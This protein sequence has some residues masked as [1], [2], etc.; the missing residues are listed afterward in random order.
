MPA[1]LPLANRFGVLDPVAVNDDDEP[2]FNWYNAYATHPRPPLYLNDRKFDREMSLMWRAKGRPVLGYIM[3][4]VMEFG[5]TEHV[6][7]GRE[8]RQGWDPESARIFCRVERVFSDFLQPPWPMD[9]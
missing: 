7:R 1:F 9:G 6:A 4:L 8:P 5:C 2:W 3:D